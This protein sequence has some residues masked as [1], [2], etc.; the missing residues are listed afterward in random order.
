MGACYACRRC[1]HSNI[2]SDAVLSNRLSHRQRIRYL[3]DRI[4]FVPSGM[5]SELQWL[6][7]MKLG[8]GSVSLHWWLF[9]KKHMKN[10]NQNF[11]EYFWLG[12][13]AAEEGDLPVDLLTAQLS[14]ERAD[15]FE[16]GYNANL[17]GQITF[18]DP[19][20]HH[21]MY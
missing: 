11:Y 9:S 8:F 6:S 18:N 19:E 7:R 2:T 4:A 12:F 14:I 5:Q 10:N 1:E 20:L 16:A 21:Y 15:A 13:T 3:T 17:N